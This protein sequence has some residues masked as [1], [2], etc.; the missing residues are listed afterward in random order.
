MSLILGL[1][2]RA[3]SVC[4]GCLGEGVHSCTSVILISDIWCPRW[5]PDSVPAPYP[6]LHLARLEGLPPPNF[7]ID[8]IFNSNLPSQSSAMTSQM[9][10]KQN[11]LFLEPRNGSS[12]PALLKFKRDFATSMR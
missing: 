1:R 5:K 11:T 3:L 9:D 4:V 10:S 2:L 6:K 7:S 12:T 8:K